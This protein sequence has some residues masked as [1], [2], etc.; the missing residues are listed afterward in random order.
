[1]EENNERILGQFP[2]GSFQR[3]LFWEQQLIAVWLKHPQ[4]MQWHPATIRWCHNIKLLSTLSY[5]ALCT[6]G[7]MQL[8]S[9]RTLRDYTH[10]VKARSGFHD[11]M[12]EELVKE[13]KLKDQPN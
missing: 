9:E 12:D 4:Q 8:L 7:S 2:E 11:D 3:L 1:M 5:H 6:S 10:Y 13:S